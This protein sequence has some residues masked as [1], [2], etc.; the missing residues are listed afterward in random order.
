MKHIDHFEADVWS[1]QREKR[2]NYV[3]F[4][5]KDAWIIGKTKKEV[6]TFLGDEG[7]YYPENRWT[8]L[9]KETWWFGNIFLAFYFEEDEVSKVKIE[10]KK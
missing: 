9:I 4:L 2:R 10:R 7:N 1:N 6:L 5:L 3:R 8:Y